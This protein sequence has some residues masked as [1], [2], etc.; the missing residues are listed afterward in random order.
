[1]EM[2]STKH[3]AGSGPQG[4]QWLWQPSNSGV[5][6]IIRLAPSVDTYLLIARCGWLC[7]LLRQTLA[8]QCAQRRLETT[9]PCVS[10]GWKGRKL[11]TALR[12]EAEHWKSGWRRK[13][14]LFLRSVFLL[15]KPFLFHQKV[16][17]LAAAPVARDTRPRWHNR[18]Q[19][20]C[21]GWQWFSDVP[22]E[23]GEAGPGPWA[24]GY[25]CRVIYLRQQSCESQS[26]RKGRGA[27]LPAC[28]VAGPAEVNCWMLKGETSN[29]TGT[30]KSFHSYLWY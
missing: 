5:M 1:M 11:L 14:L 12:K 19:A 22:R 2:K 27:C 26:G 4:S 30:E 3:L 8:E 24:E 13:D 20:S 10:S 7:T 23:Q 28:E 15:E 21:Q 29:E 9:Q 18:S 6:I 25:L 17:D 16:P